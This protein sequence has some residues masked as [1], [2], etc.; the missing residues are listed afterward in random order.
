MDA[1]DGILYGLSVAFTFNNLLA[2]LVGA[3]A[4]TLIGVLPGLGPTAGIAMIL[5]L[6]YSLDPTSGLIMMAGM[7]YGAMYG[8]ST[9]AILVNMPGESASVITCLDGY[10]LTKKGRAGAVLTIVAAG[11]FV[12]GVISVIGVMLFAPALAEVGLMFG[13]AEFFALTAGGLLL[14]SRISGG[15]LA[16]GI[17]PMAIGLMLSTVGQE[18]VTGQDRF[19]FGIADLTLGVE[20]VALVVGLYGIAEIMSVVETLQKQ[21]KP[22]PVKLRDMFPSRQEWRRSVAP[23]GRG[24]ILGF[25]FGLLPGPSATLASFAAY[26]L[27][28]SVSK[29]KHELGEGAIEGVAGPE[30]A[31]NAAATSSMVPLL[32]LGI[33]FGSVTALMLAAM[34]VHGVQPGPMMMTAHPQ[35]FWGV[36]ASMLVGN[37]MLVILNV[38]LVSVWVSLLRV[39]NHVFLPIILMM[40]SIGCYSVRNSMLDVGMLLVVSLIGYTLR[41]LEFQLAPMVVGLV[42][43]PLIEKHM[44]EGLFMS[45]GEISV[46][47]TSPIAIVIWLLVIVVLL[48]E[49]LR[50]LAARMLGIKV[51]KI[52][53]ESSE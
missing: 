20:L 5:P 47:Y 12:G 29:Y 27:E 3:L 34:M 6:S 30:T 49:P 17:F 45:L 25:I 42:L 48:L 52:I 36:I 50:E 18:A 28:K 40:A 21:I 4:G 41:K 44:R 31:N 16:A 11:S 32:A 43:G 38:P 53:P 1:L 8:G 35:V 9:T 33:P 15:S 23:F 2:A 13:P 39:P 37:V 26:R 14:F 19:T 24:T 7:F 22:L 46:F 10:K 51:K